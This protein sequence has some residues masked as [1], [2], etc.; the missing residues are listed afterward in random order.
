MTPAGSARNRLAREHAP[1]RV[2]N[3]DH[4]H[5]QDGGGG[6][7]PDDQ[8]EGHPVTGGWITRRRGSECEWPLEARRRGLVNEDS[9]HEHDRR[10]MCEDKTPGEGAPPAG[11]EPATID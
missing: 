9:Y 10:S 6:G 5:D 8:R 1:E 7:D 4:D 2:R 11:I 3:H